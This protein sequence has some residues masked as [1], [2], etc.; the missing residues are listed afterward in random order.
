MQE[1]SKHLRLAVCLA[2]FCMASMPA[3]QAKKRSVR[4]MPVHMMGLAVS[5]VDSAACLTELQTVNADSIGCKTK[6][7]ADRQ[8]YS[9]QLQRHLIDNFK[10]GPYIAAVF[11]GKNRKK[12]ERRYLKL[13][14]RYAGSKLYR[15]NMLDRS[16]FSFKAE[17]YVEPAAEEPEPKPAKAKK[18]KKQ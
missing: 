2:L 16:Q 12:M 7:L 17:A 15:L 6:F 11:F 5:I 13:H 14:N 10:K 3:L 18:N 4:Q 1:I 8:A 9:I